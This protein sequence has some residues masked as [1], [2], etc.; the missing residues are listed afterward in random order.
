MMRKATMI[1]LLVLLCSLAAYGQRQP[2]WRVVKSVILFDQTE[3]ISDTIFFTPPTIGVYRLS[4]YMAGSNLQ[5]G[6]ALEFSITWTD[7]SGSSESNGMIVQNGT[8]SET[9]NPSVFTVR[10]GTSVV[11]HVQA[12]PPP[13]GYTYILVLTVEKLQSD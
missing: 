12:T 9:I 1:C 10:P 7:L 11:Y 13:V 2:Q 6:T 4:G 3:P 5:S 8:L